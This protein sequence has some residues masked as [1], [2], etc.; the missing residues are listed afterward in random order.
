M[1]SLQTTNSASNAVPESKSVM[2]DMKRTMIESLQRACLLLDLRYS[3]ILSNLKGEWSFHGDTR[4]LMDSRDFIAN[5]PLHSASNKGAKAEELPMR[6]YTRTTE[7][8]CGKGLNTTSSN[9]T[10]S[11]TTS[12]NTTSSNTESSNT[13]S[14]NTTS[15]NEKADASQ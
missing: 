1:N 4:L 9:A 13:T 3:L 10:P 2:T 11:N 5:K 14:S 15:S 7:T 8:N 12:S 6:G